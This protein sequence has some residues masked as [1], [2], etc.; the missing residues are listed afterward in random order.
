MDSL[1]AHLL[2]ASPALLDP[3][4]ERT[5]VLIAE[6]NDD[7]AMGLILNRRSET[8]VSDA[9][10]DLAEIV[11][12]DEM[13]LVGGPVQSQSVIVVAEFDDPEEA[14]ALIFDDVGLAAA[15]DDV[16][17]LPG[18]TRRARVFAG[19]AGWGPGQLEAELEREDWITEPAQRDDLFVTDS[20][21]LWGSVLERKGGPYALLAR[22]P[23]D[24]SV[25]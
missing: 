21:A 22:M 4:F 17:A 18:H 24:P 11:D 12:G 15:V 25:N 8:P 3:N 7:G 9:V 16:D 23:A 10:P 14:A 2:I 20:N 13:M 19:Y 6:H 5:V 1:R